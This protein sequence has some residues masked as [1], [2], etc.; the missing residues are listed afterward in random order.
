MKDTDHPSANSARSRQNAAFP[1]TTQFLV[2]VNTGAMLASGASMGAI[3][4]ASDL[5]RHVWSPGQ[6]PF[7]FD[8]GELSI[9]L[10]ESAPGS[11]WSSWRVRR[12]RAWAQVFF[13]ETMDD[14]WA[15]ITD[16]YQMTRA[17]ANQPFNVAAG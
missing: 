7:S 4:L 13:R 1:G 3:R 15:P 2:E 9:R 14:R 16:Y 10:E 6:V 12:Y 8:P 11:G 5:I 17:G